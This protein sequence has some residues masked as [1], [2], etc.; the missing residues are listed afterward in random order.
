ME[1]S[2]GWPSL[3]VDVKFAPKKLLLKNAFWLLPHGVPT[4]LAP[5][6]VESNERPDRSPIGVTFRKYVP[7]A[8][9]T[10]NPVTATMNS[11]NPNPLRPVGVT[12]G[13]I[14]MPLAITVPP[15]P[16]EMPCRISHVAPVTLVF[17]RLSEKTDVMV[18]PLPV[19]LKSS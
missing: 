19:T 17:A 9:L 13:V 16:S 5:L 10:F 1:K 8:K 6:V 3:E 4:Q 18:H 15:F 14:V 2:L 11:V 7:G 12:T